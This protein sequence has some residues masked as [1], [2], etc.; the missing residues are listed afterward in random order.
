MRIAIDVMGGDHAPDAILEGAV[1]ALDLLGSDDRLTLVGDAPI[2]REVLA[3][4]RVTDDPRIEI[5]ATTQVISMDESPTAALRE[6]KDSSIARWAWLGSRKCPEAK[7]A[8]VILS[9]GNTGACVAAA[10]MM[11]RRLPG[12]IRLLVGGPAP[13]LPDDE[14]GQ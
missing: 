14:A 4:H 7:R 13:R 5:E 8:D 3:E 9:A 12:E 6:K 2:I 10:Q 1:A 11:L